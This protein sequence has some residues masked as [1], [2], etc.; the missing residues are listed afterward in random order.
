MPQKQKR[1]RRKR[2]VPISWYAEQNRLIRK[3]LLGLASG[4]SVPV[5]GEGRHRAS[6]AEATEEE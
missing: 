4:T 3:Y 1:G 6:V 2:W 5:T